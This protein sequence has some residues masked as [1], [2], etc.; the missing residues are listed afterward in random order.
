M[1]VV[2]K[3]VES[4]NAKDFAVYIKQVFRDLIKSAN[5][6][7]NYEIIDN[8]LNSLNIKWLTN[9]RQLKARSIIDVAVE[10]LEINI[11]GDIIQVKFNEKMIIPETY[12]TFYQIVKLI[13]YGNSE[14]K[15]SFII[16][17][18]KEYIERHATEFYMMFKE[19]VE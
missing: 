7:Y 17:K 13:N 12:V 1:Q 3:N 2:I 18:Q 19:E 11:N 14:I 16:Y 15:G 10:Y 9:K 8:Y 6:T 4:S 5:E